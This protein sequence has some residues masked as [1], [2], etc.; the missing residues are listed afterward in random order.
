M[1]RTAPNTT[2]N[3]RKAASA[4]KTI[5]SE[6]KRSGLHYSRERLDEDINIC[7]T[8]TKAAEKCKGYCAKIAASRREMARARKQEKASEV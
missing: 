5:V 4:A 1:K 3:V 6:G 2:K 8:C 7:L